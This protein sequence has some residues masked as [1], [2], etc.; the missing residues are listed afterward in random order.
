MLSMPET[1]EVVAG[2]ASSGAWIG[3]IPQQVRRMGVD[4]STPGDV[5]NSVRVKHAPYPVLIGSVTTSP[6]CGLSGGLQ[7]AKKRKSVSQ[8]LGGNDQKLDDVFDIKLPDY[9]DSASIFSKVIYH[10]LSNGSSNDL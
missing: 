9:L 6:T 4:G 2:T 7:V 8:G 3:R 10:N 5:C 1:K